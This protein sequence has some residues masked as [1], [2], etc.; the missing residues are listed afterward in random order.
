MK[1]ERIAGVHVMAEGGGYEPGAMNLMPPPSGVCQE[2]AV[3]HPPEAPHNRDSLYYQMQFHAKQGR[4]PTWADAIAHMDE[5]ARADIEA[6]I[7]EQ[8]AWKD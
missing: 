4:Q 1:R 6:F 7:R 8:G 2:C 5:A 3:D